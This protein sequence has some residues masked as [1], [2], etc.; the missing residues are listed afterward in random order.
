M[1]CRSISPSR[2][3]R[4]T[5]NRLCSVLLG[6][7]G[8]ITLN[9]G[10]S[11][12]ISGR[13]PQTL[14]VR[15]QSGAWTARADSIRN[16]MSRLR[17]HSGGLSL[18]AV[19]LHADAEQHSSTILLSPDWVTDRAFANHARRAAAV[20]RGR[21]DTRSRSKQPAT[22]V[23]TGMPILSRGAPSS[24]QILID[25]ANQGMGLG[26]WL[27]TRGGGCG[28]TL[29]KTARAAELPQKRGC[30]GSWRL[31]WVFLA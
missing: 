6:A 29:G 9:R 23:P 13:S 28:R 20:P 15:V 4:R 17:R 14:L 10:G 24:A 2:R 1:A 31:A 8:I 25:F 12:P 22:I 3:V 11:W 19:A 21:P 27:D 18:P 16:T 26:K 30:H 7:F 5:T